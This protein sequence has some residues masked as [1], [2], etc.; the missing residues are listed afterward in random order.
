MVDLR[1]PKERG[2]LL[3]A[4]RKAICVLALIPVYIAVIVTLTLVAVWVTR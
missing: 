1:L 4:S 3:R 2:V